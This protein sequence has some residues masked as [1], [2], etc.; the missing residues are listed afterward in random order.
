MNSIS[1]GIYTNTAAQ[2]QGIKLDNATR[3]IPSAE[4]IIDTANPRNEEE[5]AHFA[6]MYERMEESLQRQKTFLSNNS[7]VEQE[8]D[9]W[10]K[11]MLEPVHAV[12]EKDGEVVGILSENGMSYGNVSSTILTEYSNN[13]DKIAA[14]KELYGDDVTIHLYTDEDAPSWGEVNEQRLGYELQFTPTDHSEIYSFSKALEGMLTNYY[15]RVAQLNPD[16]GSILDI[17]A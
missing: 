2:S 14:L 11:Q 1:T 7:S 4:A 9:R 17:E 13:D 6:S 15:E 12:I 10:E 3:T 5:A 16:S 8:Y